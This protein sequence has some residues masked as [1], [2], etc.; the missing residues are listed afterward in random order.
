M[1]HV[2]LNEFKENPEAFIASVADGKRIVIDYGSH[3]VLLVDSIDFSI[4]N[5]ALGIMQITIERSEESA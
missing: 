2:S 3:S 1:I 5:A 4:L